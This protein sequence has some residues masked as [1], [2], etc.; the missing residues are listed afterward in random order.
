MARTLTSTPRADSFRM[1]GEFEPHAGCWMLFPM[2]PD[3]WRENGKPVQQVFAQVAE[4]IARF[5]PVT[6]CVAESGFTPARRLLSPHI[7]VIAMA[8][9]DAWMRDIGPTFLINGEGCVRAVDWQFNAWG[10]LY[11]DFSSD[12][13]VAQ[14]ML[15]IEYVD[16]YEADFVLEGGSIHVD[17]EGTLITTKECLLHPN[18][19]PHLSQ[20][21]IEE[22]LCE[23]LNVEKIIW[24]DYGVFNDETDD[25]VDNMCC[26][27]RPGVVALTWTNDKNDPQ[28][29]RSMAAYEVLASQTDARG[30]P[31][32]IHKI[33]QPTPMFIT[34][35]ESAT[36]EKVAGSH[37]RPAG[38]RL[39]ASYINFYIANN[40]IIVPI[41]NDPMDQPALAALAELFPEREIIGIYA[42]EILLGGGN[43]HCNTQHIPATPH[44][45]NDQ[46]HV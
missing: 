12:M 21:D 3:V 6:V 38:E 7:R 9:N 43:I 41:F 35:E 17:G 32:Q 28:Y 16:R 8:Y 42:R 29:E 11:S 15:E 23:Y 10:G 13:L 24:L 40:A 26:F 30:R 22:R 18:R 33:H 31:F 46:K 19:N 20:G 44:A 39:A 4:A 45:A 2:R 25:H 5:E 34:E 36:I 37:P 27:I 14:K 1:P